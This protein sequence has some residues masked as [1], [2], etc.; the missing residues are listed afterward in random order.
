MPSEGWLPFIRRPRAPAQVAAAADFRGDPVFVARR[1]AV[2]D[3]PPVL[4]AGFD[5]AA[6]VL[7]VAGQQ[8]VALAQSQLVAGW[9]EAAGREASPSA[10]VIDSQ[11]V[12]T[13]ESGG[14]SGYDAGKK[15][16]GR[17]RHILT[18]AEGNLVHAMVHCRGSVSV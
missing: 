17:K 4:P 10:G 12:K 2:T 3:A 15:T 18:D 9:G 6:L 16:K 11:S 5:G 7:P 8:A 13:T 14:P 1:A